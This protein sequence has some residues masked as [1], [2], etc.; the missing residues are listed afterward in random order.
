MCN[1]EMK[2]KT[3]NVSSKKLDHLPQELNRSQKLKIINILHNKNLKQNTA[4]VNKYSNSTKQI[5][6]ELMQLNGLIYSN[7]SRFR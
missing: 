1:T 3:K 7:I 4:S 6:I 2:M 5:K